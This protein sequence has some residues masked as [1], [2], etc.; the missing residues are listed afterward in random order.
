LFTGEFTFI[1]QDLSATTISGSHMLGNQCWGAVDIPKELYE[2]PVCIFEA[3]FC[4]TADLHAKYWR[5]RN[6]LKLDWLKG[7]QWLQGKDRARWE[8]AMLN[9]R[10]RWTRVME[11]VKSG[12]TKV[13]WSQEVIKAM[14]S[15]LKQ[16]SWNNYLRNFNINAENTPFTICHGDY[17]AGNLLWCGKKDPQQLLYF[18]DWSEVG[19]FCP[20]TDLAQFLISNA[21]VEVRR[22]Y[23]K[24][25]IRTYYDRLVEK[26]ISQEVFPFS[27][28][29]LRYQRGGME[30]WLSMLTLLAG[31]SL[32]NPK[33]LPDQYIS[34]FHN[35]VAEF[36]ADHSMVEPGPLMTAYCM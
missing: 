4:R 21:T 2:D 16:T 3:V 20:F 24:R 30:K 11:A 33:A 10:R 29:W 25:I 34:W 32:D 36:L 31:L 12:E 1:M 19:V 27:D 23:E 5:D 7:A 15:S 22:Q 6:L 35:Q 14:E 17:H 9:M 28:C 13:K 18:I 26:G 8:L